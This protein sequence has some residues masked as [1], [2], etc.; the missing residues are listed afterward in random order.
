ME[1]ASTPQYQPPADDPEYLAL[2]QQAEQ[3]KT[4]A[5]QQ[6]AGMDSAALMARYGS[7]LTAAQAAGSSPSMAAPLA[8]PD[9]NTMFPAL[10]TPKVA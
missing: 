4:A 1:S 9:L 10:T 3:D 8:M 5:L 2:K 7:R 6:R